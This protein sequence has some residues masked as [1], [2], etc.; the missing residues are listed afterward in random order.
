M[1]LQHLKSQTQYQPHPILK[2]VHDLLHSPDRT[3]HL[4]M[5]KSP[6]NMC[7][8]LLWVVTEL[9]NV[10]LI[11]KSIPSQ[12]WSNKVKVARLFLSLGVVDDN[13]ER[14]SFLAWSQHGC[15]A[16]AKRAMTVMQNLET[17]T[18]TIYDSGLWSHPLPLT[19]LL[20]IHS[21]IERN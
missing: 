16:S 1:I 20:I 7:N 13:I 21:C 12:E 4:T 5:Q 15:R 18:D 14:M 10:V 17:V 6:L 8:S 9:V 19:V 11:L 3:P 2:S